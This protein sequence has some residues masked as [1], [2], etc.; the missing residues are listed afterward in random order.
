MT[1]DEVVEWHHVLYGHEFDQ[2]P[3]VGDV[4]GSLECCS[5]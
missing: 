5:P 4:Q 2:V 1:E 3:E